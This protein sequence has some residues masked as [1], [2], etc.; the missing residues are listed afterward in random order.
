MKIPCILFLNLTLMTP[1]L[2]PPSL[3]PYV[4]RQATL[5]PIAP[6]RNPTYLNFLGLQH[7]IHHLHPSQIFVPNSKPPPSVPQCHQNPNNHSVANTT[8]L[9]S[10]L[11]NVPLLSIDATTKGAVGL[12]LVDYAPLCTLTLRITQPIIM[13]LHFKS[14]FN[15]IPTNITTQIFKSLLFPSQNFSNL[16]SDILLFIFRLN[17]AELRN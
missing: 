2:P 4:F 9:V 3:S 13:D 10:A 11:Q 7:Q 5:H 17:L 16:N 14:L 6:S 12:T 1:L 15:P 8:T